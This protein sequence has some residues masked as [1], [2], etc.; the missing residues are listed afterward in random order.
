MSTVLHEATL[1]K[2]KKELNEIPEEKEE[3]IEL[4][5]ERIKDAQTRNELP[6]SARLDDR[7]LIRFLRARKYNVNK[8]LYLYSDYYRFR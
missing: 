3:K 2:A 6:Q 7:T 8:A 1:S 5:R 4:L